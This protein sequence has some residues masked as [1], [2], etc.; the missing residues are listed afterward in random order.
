M[1]WVSTVTLQ[2]VHIVGRICT[3]FHEDFAGQ[4][5]YGLKFF[6]PVLVLFT[7]VSDYGNEY[8]KIINRNLD[9]TKKTIFL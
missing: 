1:R 3:R 4:I 2:S 9:K 7:F 6:K 5:F 8:Y